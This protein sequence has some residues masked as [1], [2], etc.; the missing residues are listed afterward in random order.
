MTKIAPALS[1][2]VAAIAIKPAAMC[3]CLFRQNHKTGYAQQKPSPH[4]PV[5]PESA[6]IDAQFTNVSGDFA[7]YLVLQL[8][9]IEG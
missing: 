2:I 7:S 1:I 4:S 5:L 8:H 9:L 6:I 3:Q